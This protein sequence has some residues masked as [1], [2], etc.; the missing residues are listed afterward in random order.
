[1]STSRQIN[2]KI[3]TLGI[4]GGMGSSSAA[5]LFCNIVK[6]TKAD[7][8]VGHLRIFIDNDP[9]VPDRTEAIL[10]GSNSPA[11]HISQNIQKRFY[12]PSKL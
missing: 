6:F 2:N 1:M 12:S 4:I 8:D 7:G 11:L 10:Q 9:S 5:S 3:K